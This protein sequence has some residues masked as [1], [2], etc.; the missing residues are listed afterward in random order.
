MEDPM[1][2]TWRLLLT[3]LAVAIGLLGA[4]GSA[5]AQTSDIVEQLRALPGVTFVEEREAPPPYRYFILT[6]RQPSDHARPWR[7]SFEQ[8][9]TLLHRGTD[10]PVVM[11]TNGYNVSLEPGRAEPTRLT[12]GNQL[13]VEHRFFTP[14]RPE[15]ADW[16][17]LTIWQAA[18]DLHRLVTALKPIYPQR[19]IC[20]GSEDSYWYEA[21]GANHGARIAQL[22]PD[23]QVAATATVRRW[24]GVEA[25]DRAAPRIA[26]LDDADEPLQR[27]RPHAH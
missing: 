19:W 27:R 23:E 24:S 17:T 22:T 12:D 8:R 25:T 1:V 9:F 4:T 18:T 3:A 11:N 6:Y 15:P 13:S 10:R 14:S 16:S 2:R 5:S 20:P 7:G 26:T 21:A